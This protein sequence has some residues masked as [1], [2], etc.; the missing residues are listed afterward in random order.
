MKFVRIILITIIVGIIIWGILSFR[1]YIAEPYVKQKILLDTLVTVKAYGENKNKVEEAVNKTFSEMKRIENLINNYDPQSEISRVNQKA[2]REAVKVSAE[3]FKIVKLSKLYGKKTGGVFNI[4]VEP[5]VSLWNFG[6]RKHIPSQQE[7][8][9]ILPLINLNWVQLNE[10]NQ[11]VKLAKNGMGLDLGGVAKGYAADRAITILKRYAIRNALVTTGSTTRVLGGK[12]D[13]KSWQVGI[14]HPRKQEE[15]IGILSLKNQSVS[16][17]GDYQQYFIKNGQRYHH[18]LSPFSGM[19]A[20][21]VMSV[22][23]V[24]NKSCAEADI[25][26]TAIFV[27]GYPEGMQFIERTKNLEGVIV[28]AQGKV[29]ISSGLKGKVKDLKRDL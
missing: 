13:G 5:L 23:V 21:E 22:T 11:T 3:T 16:T 25:L 7:L 27:M 26:S 10:R 24:T 17:S 9:E 29:H 14:Q 19:P 28:D 18:I 6:G 4:T 1:G 12:P 15:I 8:N 20:N 2:G